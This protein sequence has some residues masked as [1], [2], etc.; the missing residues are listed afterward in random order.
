MYHVS[1]E[2]TRSS[3]ATCRRRGFLHWRQGGTQALNAGFGEGRVDSHARH[4]QQPLSIYCSPTTGLRAYRKEEGKGLRGQKT[5][6]VSWLSCCPCCFDLDSSQNFSESLFLRNKK[7]NENLVIQ[8]SWGPGFG[9]P[10]QI[11][12][13]LPVNLWDITPSAPQFTLLHNH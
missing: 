7:K 3:T 9:I 13:I 5:W 12:I 6:P 10:L 8:V 1:S 2:G 4:F 11:A